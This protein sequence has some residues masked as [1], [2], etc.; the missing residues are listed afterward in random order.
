MK[1]LTAFVRPERLSPVIT[2][3]HRIGIDEA[4]VTPDAQSYGQQKSFSTT[5]RGVTTSRDHFARSRLDIA[6][7]DVQIDPAI[8]AI[9]AGAG[10]GHEGD[11]RIFV[12]ELQQCIN[13]QASPTRDSHS[14]R[15][16]A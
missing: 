7:D 16:P 12:T 5:Y 14:D 3:L 11:G 13:I 8:E 10:T 6:L 2:E 9:L 4:S 15:V 1:L